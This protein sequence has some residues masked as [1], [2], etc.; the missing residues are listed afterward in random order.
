M[1]SR[2]PGF[3]ELGVADRARDVQ[4]FAGLSDDQRKLLATGLDPADADAM[5]ENAVGAF[6]L[7]LGV[8]TNFTVNGEDRLVP[9]AVEESSV[10][11]AASYGAKMARE[12]G[13]FDAEATDPVMT[14][15]IHLVELPDPADA[16]ARIRDAEEDLLA[17]AD[18]AA[19]SL[20]ER[21][22]GA[23]GLT[24]RPLET[25]E[26][27]ALAVHVHVDVRDAM[28]ANAV[29]AVAE[30][31]APRL[32]DLSDGRALL[33]I[34][35]NRPARRRVQVHGVFDAEQMGGEDVVEDV[36]RAQA[37]AEADPD[38][39]TTHNKGIMN[40]IGAVAVAT[41][42]DWRAVEA[43]AHGWAARGG[44]GPLTRYEQTDEGHLEGWLELPLALGTVGG[45]TGSHP[46]AQVNLE[47]LAVEGSRELAC[48]AAS[49]GLAQ[50][51]A[52]LRA[53]V[54]EGITAGHMRLHARNLAL[55]AGVPRDRAGDVAAEMLDQDR[56]G[57][58]H[59]D[60]IWDEID[61][62]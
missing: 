21:G 37:V 33:R 8:A 34:L 10:V 57:V 23:R 44:Y 58:R 60:A 42:N 24:V 31:L 55:E 12:H 56:I 20:P 50:N 19:G 61:E 3:H 48:V 32:A 18:E 59:A 53:L 26:G 52:A 9:M 39:A 6:G 4:E 36:V 30:A 5:V 62:G 54:D 16:A 51:A 46:L 25:R 47:I 2:I 29:T 13:G 49:V 28:G 14:G 40:G 15:Q 43:G 11:A 17:M 1:S 35:T 41:G 7:P 38:R 45:V 22:G 27:P